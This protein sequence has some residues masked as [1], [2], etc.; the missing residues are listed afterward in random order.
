MKK[1][2]VSSV[3]AHAR[4][5]EAKD[6]Y[7]AGHCDRVER[8]AELLARRLGGFDE[9]WIFNLRVAAILHDIG[10]L[11]VPDSILLSPHPLSEE[12]WQVMR[13]HTVI[14]ERICRPLRSFKQVL[15]IIRYHHERWDGGGYPEGLKGESIPVTARVLQTVDVFDALCSR[16]P[17]KPP[18]SMTK[19]FDQMKDEARKGWRDP[20]L[21]YEFIRLVEGKGLESPSN[22]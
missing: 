6:A 3:R 22:S 12:E 20:E 8:F 4:S 1:I 16:R 9:K 18:Y 21:V 10:K 5:I 15:P 13:Q 2:F 7:T 19:V 11:G 14:G 17:Y